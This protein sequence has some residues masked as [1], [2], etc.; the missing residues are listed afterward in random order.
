MMASC[1]PHHG[2]YLTAAAMFRGKISMREVEEQIC[3]I[4]KRNSR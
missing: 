4:Q 3:N 2:Y 1:D